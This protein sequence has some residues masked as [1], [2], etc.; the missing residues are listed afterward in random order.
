M[1]ETILILGGDARNERLCRLM[2]TD[3]RP[4]RHLPALWR[5]A[6]HSD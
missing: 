1:K 4:V 3:G 2:E 5:R 6:A